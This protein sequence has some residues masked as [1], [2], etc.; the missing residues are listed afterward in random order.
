MSNLLTQFV[1]GASLVCLLAASAMG[2]LGASAQAM[3]QI[4]V[5]LNVVFNN[6]TNPALGGTW[7]LVAKSTDFGIASLTV[8]IA[9]PGT[10]TQRAARGTINSTDV[11]GFGIFQSTS[12]GGQYNLLAM[13]QAHLPSTGE[14]AGH[15]YGVGTLA[16]GSPEFA[17]KPMGANSIGP[18]L[19]SLTGVTNLPWATGDIFGEAAWN[20]AAIMA[21]GTFAS[22][23]GPSFQPGIE[24]S[25][26]VYK[27]LGTATTVGDRSGLNEAVLSAT[28]RTNLMSADYNRNGAIDAADY[29][30]WRDTLGATVSPGTGADGS[31]NGVIDQA[32]YTFWVA[33]WPTNPPAVALSAAIPE[34][35]ALVSAALAVG[36]ML[37][38]LQQSGV[39]LGKTSGYYVL[40]GVK[41]CGTGKQL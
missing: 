18:T 20:T 1:R 34:P 10:I 27:T 14:Q 40:S 16:N 21:S 17:G 6:P 19:S 31:R 3:P 38:F 37:V 13:A 41:L 32:D 39:F 7:Q 12:I 8:P 11:A 30:V 23:Y 28:L 22:G 24:L 36:A 2:L 33:A 9:N 29:T 25:G 35:N 4:D 26:S 15:F 5:G